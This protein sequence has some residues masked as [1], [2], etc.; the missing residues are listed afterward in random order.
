MGHSNMKRKEMQF[1]SVATRLP[2]KDLARA[3]RWYAEKLG[4]EPVEERRG[5]LRYRI[6]DGEFSLFLSSGTS[7][8]TFTQLAITVADLHTTAA[9]LRDRGVQLLDYD[10]P[11][12]RTVDGIARVEGNYP[13]KG[14]AELG[15]WFFDSE[16]NMIAIGQSLP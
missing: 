16:G 10:S 14:S 11:P 9:L 8:G 5:G 6:G 7:P 15:C 4:L 2:T 3:R 12:L 1:T 13:S